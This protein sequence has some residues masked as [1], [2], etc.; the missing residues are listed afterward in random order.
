MDKKEKGLE[1]PLILRTLRAKL[2]L[3]L[4]WQSVG[5]LFEIGQFNLVRRGYHNLESKCPGEFKGVIGKFLHKIRRISGQWEAYYGPDYRTREVPYLRT[6]EDPCI[7]SFYRKNDC[8]FFELRERQYEL[9]NEKP[10]N[11]MQTLGETTTY[12]KNIL[13][14]PCRVKSGSI[15]GGGC[16]SNVAYRTLRDMCF[17]HAM[18]WNADA[19]HVLYHHFGKFYN[20]HRPDF[21]FDDIRIF[22]EMIEH[23]WDIYLREDLDWLK[24]DERERPNLLIPHVSFDEIFRRSITVLR[25]E[26]GF[27]TRY[28]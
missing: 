19:A 27:D 16:H 11:P 20:G 6:H 15:Y 10:Q 23:I 22:Y 21:G 4:A 18:H 2:V 13:G 9:K 7:D 12:W 26:G 1:G 14:C 3:E 25:W 8:G 24:P 5:H 28:N 17:T